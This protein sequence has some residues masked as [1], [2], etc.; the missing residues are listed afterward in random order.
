MND[1]HRNQLDSEDELFIAKL[2][3]D[4]GAV[5]FEQPIEVIERR[6]KEQQ[7]ALVSETFSHVEFRP[8]I[9]DITNRA[10]ALRSTSV[11]RPRL[12]LSI[13]AAVVLAFFLSQFAPNSA[14]AAWAIV[15]EDLSISEKEQIAKACSLP[16]ERGLGV[17]ESSNLAR[18]DGKTPDLQSSQISGGDLSQTLPPLV[19]ADI[20]GRS[21]IAIF[22]D[23]KA[24]VICPIFNDGTKWQDQGISVIP[25]PGEL[26]PGISY[27]GSAAK[28]GGE[29]ISYIS[30]K[31]PSSTKSVS[32]ELSDGRIV[33]ASL[34]GSMY[35]AWVPDDAVIKSDSIKFNLE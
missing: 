5:S 27:G 16:L 4:F 6:S 20:R 19:V 31:A 13:A 3:K 1:D 28:V 23:S 21:G 12:R 17:L 35:L 25:N 9:S 26:V 2:V 18:I 33:T 11:R 24:Q 29:T 14:P 34:S 8:S 22:S 7:I 32:F 10:Q 15:P 30:G